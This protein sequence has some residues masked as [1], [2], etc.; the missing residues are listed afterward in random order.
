M[1]IKYRINPLLRVHI[2]DSI[3]MVFLLYEGPSAEEYFP[4]Q[5]NLYY[6]A[7]TFNIVREKVLS[8]LT[9]YKDAT[10]LFSY[11]KESQYIYIY[12]NYEYYINPDDS[13]A[14]ITIARRTYL[15]RDDGFLQLT[16]NEFLDE[17]KK[18]ADFTV[19]DPDGYTN[20]REQPTTQSKI[21]YTIKKGFGGIL[22]ITDNPN[23]YRVIYTEKDGG[24]RYPGKNNYIK[25]WIHKSCICFNDGYYGWKKG[26]ENVCK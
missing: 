24:G 11:I 23:W 6:E 2:N 21:L 17:D 1:I 15:L 4:P 20:V 14:F 16:K 12:E 7:Y 8:S 9:L 19:T 18:I 26:Q 10:M 22:E 13:D 5:T 3:C 25:G